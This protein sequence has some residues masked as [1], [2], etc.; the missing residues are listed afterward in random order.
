MLYGISSSAAMEST[1]A[2]KDSPG[3][4]PGCRGVIAGD[5]YG[6]VT[7]WCVN[8]ASANVALTGLGNSRVRSAHGEATTRA[9]SA[10]ASG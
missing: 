9:A 10:M 3:R 2:E 4:V 5:V 6:I 8:T 7:L 1:P